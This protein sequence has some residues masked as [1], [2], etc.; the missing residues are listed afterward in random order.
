MVFLAEKELPLELVVKI[1]KNVNFDELLWVIPNV[2]KQ[3]RDIVRKYVWN[4]VRTFMY[5]RC[6]SDRHNYQNVSYEQFNSEDYNNDYVDDGFSDNSDSN[7]KGYEITF[8]D[9]I[10]KSLKISDDQVELYLRA[11]L[12]MFPNVQKLIFFECNFSVDKKKL[13]K[14]LATKSCALRELEV[15][16]CGMFFTV[17]MLEVI[18]ELKGMTKL[19]FEILYNYKDELILER[20]NRK[21]LD[22]IASSSYLKTIIWKT[23]NYIES[24]TVKNLLTSLTNVSEKLTELKLYLRCVRLNCNTLVSALQSLSNCQIKTLEFEVSPSSDWPKHFVHVL[25]DFVYLKDLRLGHCNFRHSQNSY[26][27]LARV[28]ER[29]TYLEFYDPIFLKG[30][31]DDDRYGPYPNLQRLKFYNSELEG[32]ARLAKTLANIEVLALFVGKKC[33]NLVEIYSGFYIDNDFIALLTNGIHK[34]IHPCSRYFI[35][36]ACS[37]PLKVS[38]NSVFF[39][40]EGEFDKELLNMPNDLCGISFDDDDHPLI[41]RSCSKYGR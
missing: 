16:H 34:Y 22:H 29:L 20:F 38:F 14:N 21:F 11:M 10:V 28:I 35:L 31:F 40:V 25:V 37:Q 39:T 36:N 32:G 41:A 24:N 7:Y 12:I 8:V 3:W 9:K 33:P 4:K 26:A 6:R 2:C 19:R 23:S 1:F 30:F 13:I 18:E 17:S 27:S 15:V 5:K